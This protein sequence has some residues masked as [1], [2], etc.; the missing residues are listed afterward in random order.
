M[1]IEVLKSKIHC[2]RL[3]QTELN[4]NGSIT[5]DEDLIDA[6]NMIANEKVLIVNNNNGARFETY[7]IAGK[8]GTGIIGFKRISSKARSVG[9]HINHYVICPNGF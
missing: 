9:R 2:A 5:V 8:R 3:T 6:A 1:Q 7:V 4:Y